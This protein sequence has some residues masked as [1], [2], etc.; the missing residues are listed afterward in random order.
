M[1]SA[2]C[3]LGTSFAMMPH[4]ANINR[5][6]LQVRAPLRLGNAVYGTKV[7]FRNVLG[8]NVRRNARILT[9]AKAGIVC[10]AAPMV[11]VRLRQAPMP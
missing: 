11:E 10:S 9:G 3:P 5:V 2:I 7:A 1:A 6:G 8:C 4:A